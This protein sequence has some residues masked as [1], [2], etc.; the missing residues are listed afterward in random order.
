[1]VLSFSF[2]FVFLPSSSK[3]YHVLSFPLECF[4]CHSQKIHTSFACKFLK[5][6]SCQGT[7]ERSFLSVHLCDVLFTYEFFNKFH[8]FNMSLTYMRRIRP[9]RTPFLKK[10]NQFFLN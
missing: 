3:I 4:Q 2:H 6:F 9:I 7:D 1:M 10:E 5:L 8:S